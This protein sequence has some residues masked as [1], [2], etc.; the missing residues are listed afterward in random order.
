MLKTFCDVCGAELPNVD[1][2]RYKVFDN[3]KAVDLCEDHYS[4][5]VKLLIG[6]YDNKSE[7]DNG[8]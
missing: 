7:A 4:K 5:L 2:R 6:Q 8:K 3:N 1:I